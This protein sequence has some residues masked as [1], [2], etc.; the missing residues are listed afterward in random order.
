MVR[1][2]SG[3]DE[4]YLFAAKSVREPCFASVG[5]CVGWRIGVRIVL[6]SDVV[7]GRLDVRQ[8]AEALKNRG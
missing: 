8:V 5:E 4:L 2:A 3:V 1:P 7:V 6:V